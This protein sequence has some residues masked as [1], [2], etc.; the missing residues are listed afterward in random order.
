[1]VGVV[2]KIVIGLFIWMVLPK[3]IYG[4]RKYS[5]DT[6]QFFVYLSCKIVGIAIIIFAILRFLGI[7]L[8]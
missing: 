5:K 7:I 8:N 3:L 2:I 1:M 6:P 4:T